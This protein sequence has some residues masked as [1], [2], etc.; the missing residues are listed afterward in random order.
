MNKYEVIG[1]VNEGAYGI[2]YKAKNRET[3]EYVAIKKFKETDDD[4]IVRKT[5]LREVKVLRMIKHSNVVQLKE[6]FKRKGRLFLVF[7]YCDNNLLEILEERANGIA[8][9][10]V[11]SFI[12]QLLKSIEFCHRHGVIHRDIKPENLLIDENT[13]VLKLCDFGFARTLPKKQKHPLTD[14]VATRWY[15]SP[16]LLLGINYSKEVDMWAI[17]CIMGEITDGDPLFPGESEIDQLYLIQKVLGQLTPEQEEHFR[18][19]PRFIGLSFPDVSK[20]ETLQK[21]YVGKMS[22][23]AISLMEGFLEMD[24]AQRITAL[25]ALAH[26][27]FDGIRDEETNMLIKTY[28]KRSRG[29]SSSRAD[30]RS[31]TFKRK[32]STE[33]RNSQSKKQ[34]SPYKNQNTPSIYSSKTGLIMNKKNAPYGENLSSKLL[35]KESR[36]SIPVGGFDKIKS[37]MFENKQYQIGKAPGQEEYEYEIDADFEPEQKVH[38]PIPIT[39]T[40]QKNYDDSKNL[41]QAFS[42]VLV[43][44]DERSPSLSPKNNKDDKYKYNPILEAQRKSRKNNNKLGKEIPH[45]FFG[46]GSTGDTGGL[47]LD[48][49]PYREE[50]KSASMPKNKKSKKKNKVVHKGSDKEFQILM[51]SK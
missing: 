49:K 15:R 34:S 6:A 45:N 37:N 16:E 38:D 10:D 9:E 20:P 30:N 17:G 32:S 5:T 14:Y 18:K 33:K 29:N 41:E 2:V 28:L 24:P 22:K 43:Q 51:Q 21:H 1:I 35:K 50:E 3:N 25:E 26:P 36:E 8:P 47:E 31:K 12:F 39:I 48:H 44:S 27:Y 40:N 4:E 13:N 42:H 11:K 7:E 23:K 46:G 19:N